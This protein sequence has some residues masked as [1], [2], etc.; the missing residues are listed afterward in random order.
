MTRLAVIVL[1]GAAELASAKFAVDLRS[2]DGTRSILRLRG[3]LSFPT[4]PVASAALALNGLNGAAIQLA[5]AKATEVYCLPKRTP[6]AFYLAEQ[7]GAATLSMVLSASLTM[8]GVASMSAQAWAVLP[9]LMSNAKSIAG[10][11]K[12]SSLPPLIGNMCFLLGMAGVFRGTSPAAVHKFFAIWCMLCGLV[13]YTLPE[14]GWLDTPVTNESTIAMAKFAGASLAAVGLQCA[15]IALGQAPARAF[16]IAN[17]LLAIRSL[18][19]GFLTKYVRKLARSL[20]PADERVH[21]DALVVG[22]AIHAVTAALL[23]A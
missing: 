22:T 2:I 17:I 16:G 12:L 19:A 10:A 18:D 7:G 13:R 14:K 21:R 20:S 23:T 1:I 6:E 15:A 5:P 9:L 3:G 11:F 8:A 4:V